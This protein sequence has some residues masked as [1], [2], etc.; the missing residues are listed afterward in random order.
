MQFH[1]EKVSVWKVQNKHF[2]HKK[3]LYDKNF[4]HTMKLYDKK[5]VSKFCVSTKTL[6]KDFLS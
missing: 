2:F 3:K 6:A 1:R 4:F 5:F